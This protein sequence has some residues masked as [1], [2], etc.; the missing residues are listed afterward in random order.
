[1]NSTGFDLRRL[2][3][4]MRKGRADAT[5]TKFFYLGW[6]GGPNPYEAWVL[7]V[8]TNLCWRY[9]QM[10]RRIFGGNR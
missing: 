8:W 3:H 5:Y 9:Y 7:N 2:I 6:H 10:K 1:M 4:G